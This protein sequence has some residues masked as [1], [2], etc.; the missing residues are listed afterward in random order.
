MNSITYI[1]RYNNIKHYFKYRDIYFLFHDIGRLHVGFL[2]NGN[3]RDSSLNFWRG[4]YLS[5]LIEDLN[6]VVSIRLKR[7]YYNE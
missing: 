3:V 5:N 2:S 1:L 4:N 6:I 7:D